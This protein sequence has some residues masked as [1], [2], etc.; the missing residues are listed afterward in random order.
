[1]VL[2]YLYLRTKQALEKIYGWGEQHSVFIAATYGRPQASSSTGGDKF[3]STEFNRA[4]L[5]V[6]VEQQAPCVQCPVSLLVH[7]IPMP[8]YLFTREESESSLGSILIHAPWRL[9]KSRHIVPTPCHAR[10]LW[11]KNG[12]RSVNELRDVSFSWWR[13]A[14]CIYTANLLPKS[15]CLARDFWLVQTRKITKRGM[16]GF[17]IANGLYSL[18]IWGHQFKPAIGCLCLVFVGGLCETNL[19]GPIN[20]QDTTKIAHTHTHTQHTPCWQSQLRNQRLNGPGDWNPLETV[21]LSHKRD[22]PVVRFW[23]K[24][25]LGVWIRRGLHSL[26]LPVQHISLALHSQTHTRQCPKLRWANKRQR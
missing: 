23:R 6:P 2:Q 11:E 1:M 3:S 24:L 16:H 12:G 25:A 26:E 18:L 15:C 7:S 5:F 17:G 10:L 14:H 21:P 4:L 20:I 22:P 8:S 13:W 9:M 19:V